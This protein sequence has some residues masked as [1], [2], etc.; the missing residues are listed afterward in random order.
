MR[1]ELVAASGAPAGPGAERV[2]EVVAAVLD[3]VNSPHTRRAYRRALRD[4]LAWCHHQQRPL[5]K[6]TVQR[7]VGTLREQGVGGSSINQRLAAIRRFAAE[8]A[9]AGHL[10]HEVARAIEG[11]RGIRQQGKRLGNWLAPEQAAALINAPDTATVKGQR[12]RALLAILIGCGLRRQELASLEWRH[13]QKREQRWAIVDL[14]GKGN[15]LRSVPMP[16]WAKAALDDWQAAS[17]P[18][19]SPQAGRVF[20]QV[21]RYGNIR[22]AG[23]SEQTVYAVVKE[24]GAAAGIAPHDLRRTFAKLAYEGGAD[25]KQIKESLGHSTVATTERYIGTAQSFEDAPCDRL[26][27]EL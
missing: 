7:Y 9:D 12:D 23:I 16:A 22:A 2:W 11:A 13:V 21:D 20:R 24:H 10:E 18:R 4:F 27:I 17:V 3:G 26:G 15:K 6:P 25:I 5:T 14:V 8:A 19:G 1:G